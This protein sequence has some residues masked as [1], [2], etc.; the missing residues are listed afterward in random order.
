MAAILGLEDAVVEKI[1]SDIDEVVVAA[2]YNCLDN[3]L[4]QVHIKVLN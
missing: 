4:F 2:N 1:C 3:W